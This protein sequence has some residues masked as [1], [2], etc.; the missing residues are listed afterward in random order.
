MGSSMRCRLGSGAS[1][2]S[3]RRSREGK[4]GPSPG[5]A[6]EQVEQIAGEQGEEPGPAIEGIALWA[7]P[8]VGGD[9]TMEST[10]G[11]KGE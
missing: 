5:R 3:S 1:C 11:G 7:G 2:R 9:E 8:L 10:A 6:D 4:K